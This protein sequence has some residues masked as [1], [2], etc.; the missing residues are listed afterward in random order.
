MIFHESAISPIL[1]VIFCQHVAIPIKVEIIPVA[2]ARK[3]KT[4]LHLAYERRFIHR[5]EDHPEIPIPVDLDHPCF[6]EAE[7]NRLQP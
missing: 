4:R 6:V 1:E 3:M 5:A 2:S 7:V